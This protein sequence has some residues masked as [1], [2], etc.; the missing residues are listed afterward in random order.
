MREEAT[1]FE[2]VN[3]MSRYGGS[4]AKALADA[5]QKADSENFARI[6]ATW[7]EL[8]EEY[9]LLAVMARKRAEEKRA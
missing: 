5:A 8:W 2:I 3:A 9:H 4:F 7:P 6:K 1:D